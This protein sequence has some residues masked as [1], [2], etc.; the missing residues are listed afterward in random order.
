MRNMNALGVVITYT[1]DR[2]P[3]D[4]AERW[5]GLENQ[6]RRKESGRA[7]DRAVSAA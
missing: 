7:R 2:V 4:L 5:R 6:T 1:A 3:E